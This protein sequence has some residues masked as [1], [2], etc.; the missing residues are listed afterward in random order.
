VSDDKK[1]VFEGIAG[2]AFLPDS[3]ASQEAWAWLDA[4]EGQ[5]VRIT[6]EILN[7]DLGPGDL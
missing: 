7:D 5:R 4:L 3:A 2:D 1:R 6:V